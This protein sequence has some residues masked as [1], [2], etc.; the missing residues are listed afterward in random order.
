MALA[1][2]AFMV[3]MMFGVSSSEASLDLVPWSNGSA[4]WI[5]FSR[6]WFHFSGIAFE[7]V[8]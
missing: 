3:V 5:I 8:T 7:P 6:Y 4:G 1:T 2:I